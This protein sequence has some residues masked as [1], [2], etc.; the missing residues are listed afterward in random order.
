MELKKGF[1]AISAKVN[2]ISLDKPKHSSAVLTVY[3]ISTV[4]LK[5]IDRS[6]A[7]KFKEDMIVSFA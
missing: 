2:W 1:Y 7:A 3:G 6:I 5:E 4:E